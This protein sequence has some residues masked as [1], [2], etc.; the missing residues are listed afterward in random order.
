MRPLSGP[1]WG[2]ML[3]G[4]VTL[5]IS[6]RMSLSLTE[7]HDV[8]HYVS[9]VS[10][11]VLLRIHPKVFPA[12]ALGDDPQQALAYHIYCAP[13]D[14]DSWPAGLLCDAAQSIF[15]ALN[16]RLKA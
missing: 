13:G 16:H 6:L 11:F 10:L 8:S 5:I 9:H 7:F 4:A 12:P 3:L 1:R 2:P 14:G 15:D